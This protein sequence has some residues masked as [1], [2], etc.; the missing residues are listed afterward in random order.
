V[1]LT[2]AIQ[3]ALLTLLCYDNEPRGC[4]FVAALVPSL[5]FD[6]HFREIAEA[7]EDYVKKFDRPPGDHTLDLIDTLCEKTPDVADI[8]RR[9][10]DSM[11]MTKD[12]LNREYVLS[13]ATRFCRFQ[14]LKRG[15]T[16]A[17]ELL[18]D[19]SEEN[20]EE[21]EKQLRE[22]LQASS[23]LFAPGIILADSR[24]SLAF[25]D[26]QHESFPTG[27]PQ[28]DIPK[29]GP[30]RK[31]LHVLSALPGRG[32]SWWLIHLGKIALMHGYRV[33]HVTL[34]MS[35]DEVCQRYMQ[36]LFSVSKREGQQ[37][38]KNTFELDELGRFVSWRGERIKGRPT[39]TDKG[40]RRVLEKKLKPLTRKPPL[41]I[42]EFPT[43]DLTVRQLEGYLDGLEGALGF[44]PD[45]LLV[46]YADLMRLEARN[47]R[48]D[49]G[50]LYKDLRGLGVKRNLGVATAS[51]ANREAVNTR[52]IDTH[53]IAEDFSKVA[54]AD[55]LIT[56]NQSPEEH[57]LG[58]ARLFV[59]KGRT[60]V[61]KFSV[62][63][64]Q[65]YSLGQ[66]CL[67]SVRMSGSVY[68]DALTAARA[69][70]VE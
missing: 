6:P 55:V 19:E 30:G 29:L 59:A 67:D 40:I 4:H 1:K 10:F 70:E 65:A 14:R 47:Y 27:I 69:E 41:I 63:I 25:L 45:L 44:I 51:Q 20:L 24:A 64:S 52:T 62:L 37:H 15:M 35:E 7:A 21:A 9:I 3:E 42:K 12:G 61:D 58:L 57:E 36:S 33:C 53:D 13:H 2:T 11:E 43:G 56:Y 23:D 18:Q 49:L 32:K 38:S 28:L 60:D 54:T 46:D 48:F 16:K 68:W 34:E 50:I 5:T 66:F 26:K 39:L 8:Y 17:V 22:S 31:R